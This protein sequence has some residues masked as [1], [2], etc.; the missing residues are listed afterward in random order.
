ML[1][2]RHSASIQEVIFELV[3]LICKMTRWLTHPRLATDQT[4]TLDLAI[5]ASPLQPMVDLLRNYRRHINPTM[6]RCHK[7]SRVV[8][9]LRWNCNVVKNKL[10]QKIGNNILRFKGLTQAAPNLG[11]YID[12]DQICKDQSTE[13]GAHQ[14]PH[15]IHAQSE[16][17]L[18]S[19]TMVH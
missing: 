16:H 10:P 9:C 11:L 7:V 12:R 13:T 19:S 1:R 14:I 15:Q 4:N 2:H 3:K 6:R 17:I 8:S 18:C 5:A